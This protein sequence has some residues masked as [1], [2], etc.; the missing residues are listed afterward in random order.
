MIGIGKTREEGTGTMDRQ[1][2]RKLVGILGKEHLLLD[3]EGRTCYGY[4]A[5]NRLFPPD[6]VAFPGSA[7]EVSQILQLANEYRFPVI[8]RGAGSGFTGGAVPIQGGL[9]LSS[10]RMNRVLCID[11]ENLLAVVEPGV[12]TGDFQREVA[13][14]GLFYP[15]D[16]A[17]QDFCTLGGNVAECAGGMRALKYGVTRDYVLGLEVVLPSGEI[18]RTGGKTVK[19]VVGYDLTRLMVGSEGTLCIVTEITLKLI[20]LPEARRT[21]EAFFGDVDTATRAVTRILGSRILP[22]AMELV[23]R[24]SLDCV[25]R[26]KK[27]DVPSEAGALLLIEVDGPAAAMDG[28]VEQVAAVCGEFS[29]VALRV[30]RD[31][32]EAEGLWAI[33]RAVSPALAK[34]RPHRLNEDIVVPRSRLP[35]AIRTFYEIGRQHRVELTTFGHAGDGNLHVNVLYDRS[36][37]DESLRAEAAAEAVMRATVAMGG[38][39]SGEHGIGLTK[40]SFLPL[41]VGDG[42][43]ALMRKIKSVLDPNGILNPGKIFPTAPGVHSQ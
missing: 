33:R 4:D 20:P 40:S 29:P 27:M 3:E 7:P 37:S 13:R 10:E 14:R 36:D 28:V 32:R 6:A 19:N 41:E 30:S 24:A 5:T 23:D 42:A 12:V 8:P 35:E 17:S 16:P 39:L 9:V 21:L 43:V 26:V 11:G 2:R 25:A 18:L 15:P 1:I 34:I 38:S 22:S 31:E